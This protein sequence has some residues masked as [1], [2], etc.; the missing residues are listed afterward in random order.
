[1]SR[2]GYTDD[3]DDHLALGRWRGAVRSAI[4][5]KRGQ[6]LLRELAAALDAMPEKSLAAD[7]LVTADGQFCTLG[8]IGAARGMDMAKID[9]EDTYQVAEAFGIANA[10]ACEI[11]YQNDEQGFRYEE[12]PWVQRNWYDYAPT[13]RVDETPAERWIRM[14]KWVAD[15]LITPEQ[16]P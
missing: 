5:G 7:S 6:A 11:V 13:R 12:Q 1:M 4:F 8:A 14:R 15:H 16:Q 3:Y 9:P 10:M 2:S